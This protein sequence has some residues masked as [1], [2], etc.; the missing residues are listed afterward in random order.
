MAT[1]VV[2]LDFGTTSSGIGSIQFDHNT[3]VSPGH[4][5][6]RVSIMETQI[7]GH[8]YPKKMS[9]IAYCARNIVKWGEDAACEAT[10]ISLLKLLLL[11]EKDI[12]ADI[13]DFPE[14]KRSKTQLVKVKKTAI[15]VVADYLRRLWATFEQDLDDYSYTGNPLEKHGLKLIITVPAIFPAYYRD[16]LLEA[17][18]QSG[19]L[20]H[21][22]G[23]PT[24]AHEFVT[25]PE[26]AAYKTILDPDARRELAVGDTFMVLDCGGA[27]I[28]VITY[29]CI[30]TKPMTVREVV[31]GDGQFNPFETLRHGSES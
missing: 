15:Q 4:D 6:E 24:P 8:F 10:A 7:D 29:E 14:Y 26:A 16:R 21:R 18:R 5:F 25:E 11:D 27:T 28:D 30:T 22:S 1:V 3:K 13:L 31:P 20:E 19:I 23:L 9:K 12:R 2:P 17:I